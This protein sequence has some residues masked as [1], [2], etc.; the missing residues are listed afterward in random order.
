MPFRQTERRGEVEESNPGFIPGGPGYAPCVSLA[1][2][3]AFLSVWAFGRLAMRLL[4]FGG[5]DPPRSALRHNSLTLHPYP[6][7]VQT[8][9]YC[10]PL[11]VASHIFVISLRRRTDRRS[12]M[13][14]LADIMHLNFTWVDAVDANHPDIPKIMQHVR[15]QRYLESLPSFKPGSF[16]DA[17]PSRPLMVCSAQI[18][19]L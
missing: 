8:G 12:D 11:G 5:T 14:K 7:G 3:R 16:K 4:V 6:C 18:Y 15:A 10:G 1:T 9:Y 2:H 19:G 13:L 17:S